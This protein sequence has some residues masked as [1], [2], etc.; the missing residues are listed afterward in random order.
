MTAPIPTD[1]PDEGREQ[2]SANKIFVQQ[3][4]LLL[5]GTI[6]LGPFFVGDQ[7]HLVVYF[8]TITNN[9]TLGL[10]YYSD[11]SL[12]QFIGQQ[13][14]SVAPGAG[15]GQSLPV[16]GPFVYL[17]LS[18]VPANA[19]VNLFIYSAAGP[20]MNVRQGEIAN[21]LA[22]QIGYVGA[23]GTTFVNTS[24]VWPGEA[25][26]TTS[27]PGTLSEIRLEAVQANG[28]ITMID[29]TVGANLQRANTVFLPRCPTRLRI[30]NTAGAS[31]SYTFALC[32]RPNHPGG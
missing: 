11:A 23:P 5:T 10:D 14:L 18:P 25:H 32:A 8:D 7:S 26:F 2:P 30:V 28:T 29:T 24:Q 22:S 20:L 31:Q 3:A 9:A 19:T 1:F 16:V 21:I 13:T 4:A 12:G 17:T 6:N 15:F 27:L